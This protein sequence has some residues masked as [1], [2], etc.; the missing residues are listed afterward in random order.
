LQT[1]YLDDHVVGTV[2]VELDLGARVAVAKTKLSLLDAVLLDG[3]EHLGEVQPN[4][5]H[6]LMVSAKRAAVRREPATDLLTNSGTTPVAVHS[7]ESASLRAWPTLATVSTDGTRRALGKQR[8]LMPTYLASATPSWNLAPLPGLVCTQVR[9]RKWTKEEEEVE[10][11]E[12]EEV[13]EKKQCLFW[14][15]TSLPWAGWSP[16]SS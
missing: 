16:G 4:T 1:L 9:T 2:N 14:Q 10:E 8:V 15:T 5:T 7:I 11:E 3:L 13:E 12:E 6:L